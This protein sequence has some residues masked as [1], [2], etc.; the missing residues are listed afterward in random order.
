MSDTRLYTEF[1]DK[2]YNYGKKQVGGVLR[3]IPQVASSA[4]QLTKDVVDTAVDVG[5]GAVNVVKGLPGAVSDLASGDADL[6]G[7]GTGVKNFAGNLAGGVKDAVT[8]YVPSK[9]NQIGTGVKDTLDGVGNTVDSLAKGDPLI[10]PSTIAKTFGHDTWDG[11]DENTVTG[12]AIDTADKGFNTYASVPGSPASLG[13]E[14][15]TAA[16][17]NAAVK[18][19]TNTDS[20]E[21]KDPLEEEDEVLPTFREFFDNCT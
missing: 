21:T 1:I 2:V 12:N 10:A 14:L 13:K 8:D 15:A 6:S 11:S 7:I 20:N 9:L 5:S 4:G 18:S 17:G 3:T 16:V 19:I